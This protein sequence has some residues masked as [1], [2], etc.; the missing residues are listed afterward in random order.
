MRILAD[1]QTGFMWLDKT[2]SHDYLLVLHLINTV[3]S[4]KQVELIL[5]CQ[6]FKLG[7]YLRFY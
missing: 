5:K 2:K 4:R 6:H 1:D 7:L 3:K